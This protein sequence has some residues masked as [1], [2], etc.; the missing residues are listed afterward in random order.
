MGG[1]WSGRTSAGTDCWGL[2]ILDWRPRRFSAKPCL[3]ETGPPANGERRSQQSTC[4]QNR[5]EYRALSPGRSLVSI[6]PAKKASQPIRA[7]A[8]SAWPARGIVIHHPHAAEVLQSA[9]ASWQTS[10]K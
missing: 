3:S 8:S 4:H 6:T 7:S 9:R 1:H 2:P 5:T 10:L